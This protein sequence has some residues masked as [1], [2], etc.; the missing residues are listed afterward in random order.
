MFPVV[1]HRL[2]TSSLGLHVFYLSLLDAPYMAVSSVF[3]HTWIALAAV[4]YKDVANYCVVSLVCSYSGSQHWHC[5]RLSIAVLRIYYHPHHHP[6][7]HYY[8]HHQQH[9]RHLSCSVVCTSGTAEW[10]CPRI[11]RACEALNLHARNA[12]VLL[13]CTM[14]Y[15]GGGAESHA[16]NYGMA[17][18]FYYVTLVQWWF[19]TWSKMVMSNRG[20]PACWAPS[21]LSPIKNYS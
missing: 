21:W 1:I 19:T 16:P 17:T 4:H 5:I 3:L 6:H 13:I 11:W 8:Y 10:P 20:H 12:K 9:H 7:H 2:V 15:L 14:A 18:H